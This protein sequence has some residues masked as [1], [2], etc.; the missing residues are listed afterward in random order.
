MNYL[1][2]MQYKIK[3]AAEEGWHFHPELEF[4]FVIEGQ[5]RLEM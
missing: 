2:G 3:T 5:I 1:E 4:I